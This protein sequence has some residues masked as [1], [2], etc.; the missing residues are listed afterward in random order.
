MVRFARVE[1]DLFG[2]L[3]M[4]AAIAAAGVLAYLLCIAV[5]EIFFL[6]L[7]NLQRVTF[8]ADTLFRP[9]EAIRNIAVTAEAAMGAYKGVVWGTNGFYGTSVA[10]FGLA[11]V[12][13]SIALI[14]TAL[15][16]GIVR[17]LVVALWL[18]AA[19]VA[20]V[21]FHLAAAGHP[22]VPYRSMVQLPALV[23]VLAIVG[24][25]VRAAGA[26]AVVL[27][28]FAI[29]VLQESIVINRAAASHEL[30]AAQDAYIAGDL[31]R[32]I[33]SVGRPGKDGL[34]KI[35]T[36]G[37]SPGTPAYP[38]PPTSFMARSWFGHD[39]KSQSFRIANYMRM[40][41]YPVR[42]A[43]R[44]AATYSATWATM[45][46]WPADG[47]VVAA[48]DVTLVKLSRVPWL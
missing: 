15:R 13:G 16:N 8:Y 31:F 35:E 37:V 30:V 2:T 14:V 43:G 7:P 26:R 40:L 5:N 42:D 10:A 4:H 34:Y 48:D 29:A 27:L 36:L 17:G 20:I 24:I 32:R 47:S 39:P 9:I 41:G 21:F 25:S 38:M 23:A 22:F 12:A 28:L 18:T 11:T 19:W 33:A 45:P 3:L 6:L 1:I 46:S 44:G